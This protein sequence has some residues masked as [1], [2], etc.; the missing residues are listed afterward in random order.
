VLIAFAETDL[1]IVVE[2]KEW[3]L[4]PVENL[5]GHGGCC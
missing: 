5:A 3:L 1:L 2:R 4:N